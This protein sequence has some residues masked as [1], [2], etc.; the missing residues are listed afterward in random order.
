MNTI[1]II[2][3]GKGYYVIK[4]MGNTSQREF[5]KTEDE[6]KKLKKKWSKA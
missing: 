3:W 4:H 1:D 2:K 6:A 5:V